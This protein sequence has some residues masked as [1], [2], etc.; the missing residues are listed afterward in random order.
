MGRTRKWF[1]RSGDAER[2]PYSSKE[3][4]ALVRTGDISAKDMLWKEGMENWV[5]A[6]DYPR[7][8][9]VIKPPQAITPRLRVFGAAAVTLLLALVLSPWGDVSRIIVSDHAKVIVLVL[10]TGCLLAS[11][12]LL[13]FGLVGSAVQPIK[14][15]V[16]RKLID[17]A[18]AGA[19]GDSPG[20]GTSMTA[21][22]QLSDN[23]GGITAGQPSTTRDVGGHT[24]TKPWRSTWPG[25]VPLSS[26]Y[27]VSAAVFGIVLGVTLML[28]SSGVTEDGRYLFLPV[29]GTVTYEDGSFVSESPITLKFYQVS[30]AGGRTTRAAPSVAMV[31]PG[32]GKFSALMA[33]E[34]NLPEQVTKC[35]VVVLGGFEEKLGPSV[36]SSD[37]GD[38]ET[39]PLELDATAVPIRI[40]LPKP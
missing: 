1:V 9:R 3:I 7:L 18:S 25:K 37:Y 4:K 39:T 20:L 26:Y 14:V 33:L 40:Q 11:I 31:Q 35:R 23:L 10:S 12:G 8:F 2:G 5:A 19:V 13:T 38:P 24:P 30:A 17:T 34:K 15:P 28:R 22:G 32:T 27:V 21:T 36:L 6:G 29:R 16:S